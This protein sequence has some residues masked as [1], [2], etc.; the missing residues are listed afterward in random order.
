MLVKNPW[1]SFFSTL[2]LHI[3]VETK[4]KLEEERPCEDNDSLTYGAL[5]PFHGDYAKTSYHHHAIKAKKSRIKRAR[6][7]ST[8]RKQKYSHKITLI[9]LFSSIYYWHSFRLKV[10]LLQN[11][12]VE[13]T[14][15]S[16]WK[17]TQ[18][19]GCC[20]LMFHCL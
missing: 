5:C 2:I 9:F 4:G 19:G 20:P 11:A 7:L 18:I 6:A 16:I 13:S 15:C 1:D 17:I 12:N 3:T 10:I 8:W 14:G